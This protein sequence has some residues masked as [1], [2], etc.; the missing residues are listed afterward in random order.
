MMEAENKIVQNIGEE[1][2][3]FLD[4]NAHNDFWQQG[5]CETLSGH[6]R[7]PTIYSPE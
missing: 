4:N 1:R 2:F 6:C 3:E 5:F 7:K